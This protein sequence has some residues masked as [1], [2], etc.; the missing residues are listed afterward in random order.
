[1]TTTQQTQDIVN[2]LNGFCFDKI[3]SSVAAKYRANIPLINA[4]QRL[5]TARFYFNNAVV[6]LP[7]TGMYRVFYF[8]KTSLRGAWNPQDNIWHSTDTI[9]SD[10]SIRYSVYDENGHLLPMCSVFLYAPVGSKVVFV[11]IEK[12][13][14]DVCIPNGESVN[15]YLTQFRT[16]KM[17]DNPWNL[18]STVVSTNTQTLTTYLNEAQNN[19]SQSVIII[20]GFS[21]T[22]L[23]TIPQLSVGDYVDIFIDPT[24]VASFI[25]EVD[26]TDNGY[27]SQKFQENREILHCPKSLNPNNIILTHDNATLYIRDV[28]SKEGVYFHRCDPDSVHQVTHNDFS[29]SRPTLNAFKAGLN[30][31]QIEVVVQVREID[32]PR[33]LR[34]ESG[35]INELYIS[36]DADVIQHL[37]GQLSSDLTF[38]EAEV[39]EQSGYVSLMFQDGNS[40]NPSRLTDYINALGYYEVGSILGVNVYTGTFTPNDL[41]FEK[42]FVQRGNPVTPLVYVNGTK[43]LQTNVEYIDSNTVG[44]VSLKNEMLLPANSPLII[45][46]LDSGNPSCIFFVPSSQTPSLILPTGYSLAAYEQIEVSEQTGYQRSSNMTYVPVSISP[47]TYQNFTTSTGETEVVF[48]NSCFGKTY[49]FFASTFMW[50]QQNNIDS[51]LQNAAPLIFPIEI[52]NAE[53]SF[54]PMLNYQNI[55]VYINGKYLVEGIDFV[56]GNVTDSTYNGVMM[57]DIFVNCSSFLELE[58]TGNVLEIYISSD[59]PPSRSNGNVV[60]NN[61]NRDNAISFWLPLVSSAFIEGSPYLNLTDNAVYMTANTDIGN[62]SVYELKPLLPEG[63]SNWLSQYSPYQDDINVEKI[64]TFYKR[65]LPP[66]PDLVPVVVEHRV[67]STYITA[68]INAMITGTISPIYDSNS[69]TFLSQFDSFSYIKENDPTLVNG[70]SINRNYVSVAACYTQPTPMTAEQTR[71]VQTLV[72]LV[73]VTK[74]VVIKETLV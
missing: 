43:V 37:R 19:P 20:N 60:N 36:D 2:Y 52:E 15:L 66:L 50:Y 9:A 10:L 57:T 40:T 62:G 7:T 64:N 5:Q 30:S 73:L 53:N 18:I 33:T 45:R 51:L 44:T 58:Q 24:I 42:S 55:E 11:A 69:E 59:T 13:A 68:I 32:D 35:W 22:D 74:P 63:I 4:T 16:T 34:I 65:I 71:I 67:Y 54:L 46:T 49:V 21:Y 1:M 56:L 48:N 28:N 26:Q 12:D 14:L 31:S 3:W 8:A 29:A 25:V 6:G 23:S 72:D 38:W 17:L 27:Y 47:T 41:G 61:L 39:L 70:N